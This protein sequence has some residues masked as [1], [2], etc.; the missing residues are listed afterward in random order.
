MGYATHALHL[1]AAYYE[2]KLT[3]LEEPGVHA[4]E[5]EDRSNDLTDMSLL[6]E[7]LKP[8]KQ[9]KP[10][11]EKLTDRPPE[12]LNWMGTS[13][14]LTQPLFNF[15][16]KGGYSPVYVRQSSN[17]LTGEHTCIMLKSF[18]QSQSDSWLDSF[19]DDFRRRFLSLLSY[20]FSSFDS[21]LA[22][23][24]LNPYPALIATNA[25]A[26]DKESSENVHRISFTELRYL[27][28]EW[29]LK[30]LESYAKNLVDYHMVLDLVPTVAK[31]FFLGRFTLSL[32]YT[33]CSLLMAIG[34]QH[35]S[36]TDVEK[37]MNLASNQ[38]LAL[39]NRSIRKIAT[40]M[41]ALEEQDVELELDNASKKAL[42]KATPQKSLAAPLKTTLSKE[43]NDFA[44]KDKAKSNEKASQ[45]A[46][47]SAQEL[48]SELN[49]HEYILIL[50][51]N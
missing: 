12:T 26:Y 10:L 41:R 19:S 29:D 4:V 18:N 28:T 49:L 46:K 32:S 23:S 14:G 8:R 9:L 22:L 11:M 13:Y 25:Q 48:I 21:I 36:V 17:D 38:V 45:E 37:E 1:L 34:L 3:N 40:F 31:L 33:Q 39:F 15:W 50:F 42:A 30:R 6:E 16:K 43:L 5:E 51:F 27:L 35:K 24:V 44:A 7:K 47:S 2:G 20:S